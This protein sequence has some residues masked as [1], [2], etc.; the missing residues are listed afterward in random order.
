MA[1]KSRFDELQELVRPMKY[2]YPT[3]QGQQVIEVTCGIDFE[4]HGRAS[5]N[6]E[7][8]WKI[9]LTQIHAHWKMTDG[10]DGETRYGRCNE[11]VGCIKFQGRTLNE[12]CIRA[13]PFMHWYNAQ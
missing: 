11:G 10:P 2:A 6:W 9:Y 8:V 12:A 13:I 3:M 7:V 5:E 4:P 1:T